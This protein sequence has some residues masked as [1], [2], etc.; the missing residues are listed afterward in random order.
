MADVYTTN[1]LYHSDKS[2]IKNERNKLFTFLLT[3]TCSF[4]K[5][6]FLFALTV[7]LPLF[8]LAFMFVLL[9]LA[10]SPSTTVSAVFA[11]FGYAHL[12]AAIINSS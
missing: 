6:V 7:E 4:K 10:G 8:A 9:L 12:T 2:F 11:V 5:A 1:Q 3:Q